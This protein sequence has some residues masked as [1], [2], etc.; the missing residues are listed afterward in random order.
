[1][2]LRKKE[3]LCT[4]RPR[5]GTLMLE[6]LYYPDE[7]SLERTTNLGKTKV[8][9]REM[10]MAFTLIDLLRKPFRPEEYVDHYRSALAE[11]IEAKL[12]GKEVV[13]APPPTET[14]V[15]DLAEALAR[16][17]RKARG[18]RGG[19]TAARKDGDATTA[20][21]RKRKTSPTRTRR[22]RASA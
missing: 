18:A 5:R 12:E 3:Q 7:V 16:S 13:T 15:I 6:T 21:R 14:K 19:G 8:G 17:V 2:T 11:L 4:L 10:E 20:P 9:E 22:R 1:V